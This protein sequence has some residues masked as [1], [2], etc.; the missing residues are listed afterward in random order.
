VNLKEYC[1]RIKEEL[2][3]DWDELF[4]VESGKSK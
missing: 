3:P 2:Y 1:E 4:V